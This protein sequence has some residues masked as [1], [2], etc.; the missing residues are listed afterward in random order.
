MFDLSKITE[1][2]TAFDSADKADYISINNKINTLEPLVDALI[3]AYVEAL[4]YPPYIDVS[5]LVGN[6]F[7]ELTD[8]AIV[9]GIQ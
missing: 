5:L 7:L 3:N 2:Y 8:T 1:A 9:G 4:M 6:S